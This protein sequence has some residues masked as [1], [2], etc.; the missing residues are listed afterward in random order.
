MTTSKSLPS[1]ANA[2]LKVSR[3]SGFTGSD[4]VVVIVAP[5]GRDARPALTEEDTL[6]LQRNRYHLE[7]DPGEGKQ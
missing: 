1:F 2:F 3:T 7:R 6:N 4:R 5:A